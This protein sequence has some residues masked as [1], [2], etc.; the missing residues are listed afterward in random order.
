MHAND[1]ARSIGVQWLIDP[2]DDIRAS[3]WYRQ[4]M[5]AVL[6]ARALGQLVDEPR[7]HSAVGGAPHQV[8]RPEALVE[9]DRGAEAFSVRMRLL[10]E[11]ATPQLHAGASAPALRR[12]ISSEERPSH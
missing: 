5:I 7:Q 12:R 3:A 8:V 2:I 1:V 9:S 6:V 4:R 10:A 11:A